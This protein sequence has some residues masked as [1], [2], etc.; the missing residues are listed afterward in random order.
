MG[1]LARAVLNAAIASRRASGGFTPFPDDAINRAWLR[2]ANL[3]VSLARDFRARLP[4]VHRTCE[5]PVSLLKTSAAGS[6]ARAPRGPI[7]NLA[8]LC[9]AHGVAVVD[10]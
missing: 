10:L 6:V 8:V 1:D 5:I 7:G 9:A 2:I 3:E 4:A